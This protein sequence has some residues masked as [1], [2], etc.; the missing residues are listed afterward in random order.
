[1]KNGAIQNPSPYCTLASAANA[2]AAHLS[3]GVRNS[4]AN[5]TRSRS[6][7]ACAHDTAA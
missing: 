4:S 6:W 5:A 3:D 2:N 1:M 7:S